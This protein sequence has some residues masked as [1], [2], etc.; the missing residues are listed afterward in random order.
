MNKRMKSNPVWRNSIAATMPT[1]TQ[2]KNIE[3][4]N[5]GDAI[6]IVTQKFY[7]SWVPTFHKIWFSDPPVSF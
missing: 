2:K 6:W 7:F 4:D 5:V 3:L 1:K